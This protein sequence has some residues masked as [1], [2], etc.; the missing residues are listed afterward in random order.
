MSRRALHRGQQH[1]SE[2]LRSDATPQRVTRTHCS[3]HPLHTNRQALHP[4]HRISPNP[5][6]IHLGANALR[7]PRHRSVPHRRRTLPRRLPLQIRP[8]CREHV[9]SRPSLV[10]NDS[11]SVI[12]AATFAR[13]ALIMITS[14]PRHDRLTLDRTR[15]NARHARL[16]CTHRDVT[17]LHET[18][19]QLPGPTAP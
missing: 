8:A 2:P 13:R 1:P 3:R 14:L 9:R 15:R 6:I 18:F 11:H 12:R 5:Q 16:V 4:P 17:A 10:H 7:T 19:R